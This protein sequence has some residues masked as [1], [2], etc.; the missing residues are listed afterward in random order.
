MEKQAGRIA[1]IAMLGGL[2]VEASIFLDATYEGDLLAQAGVG[3]HVG[4]E[5]NSVF[6]ETL[7]GIQVK[8]HH[9]FSHPVDPFVKEADPSS[10][11]LPGILAEDLSKS[12]GQGDKR[13]QAYNFRVCMTNDPALRIEW[14]KPEG[15]EPL[16]YVLAGRW[17]RG[18]KDEYNDQLPGTEE[19][20]EIPRK[21]DV[22]PNKTPGGFFK[23]DTN[24]HGPVSSDFIGAN[25]AYP[26]ASYE[27]REKIFQAHVTYQKGFYW[28]MANSQDVPDRYRTAYA[29]WGLPRDEFNE[30]AHWPHALYV[31][32]ARRMIGQYV[33]T[34]PDIRGT[35]PPTSD[36]V[37]MG[38]Y[39]MDSHN[40]S[41]FVTMED[42]KARVLNEGDV[43]AHGF[44]PYAIPY[45]ALTPDP[46]ECT[47]L[48]VPVCVSS[49][50]IAFGSA[51]M[52]PVFMVLG[53]KRRHGSLPGHRRGQNRAGD[54][55]RK[56][57][58]QTAGR[59]AGAGSAEVT[60][61]ILRGGALA[62]T[63]MGPDDLLIKAH[64][65]FQM[66][67]ILPLPWALRRG[68]WG[69]RGLLPIPPA[70]ARPSRFAPL[71]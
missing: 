17:F 27:Q 40:C 47:N 36:S 15:Y 13:V 3:Y 49:S 24:N 67:S 23:T 33:V 11:L 60:P 7:N 61:T 64:S 53:Q 39:G 69:R 32:E 70:S 44:P 34:E 37:G 41:R 20:P 28:F 58:I 14:E 71:A 9:Q 56:A 16:Q 22:F 62:G 10:G 46:R 25:H 48:L 59:R 5:D 8:P 12:Q 4:R 51:R 42:G 29:S 66:P 35:L 54:P 19:H 50:H 30:T 57:Q 45:R 65:S 21:F 52:E 18:P 55:L 63:G 38:S 68:R 43:Q 26:E 6:G 31:R 1:S 2:S